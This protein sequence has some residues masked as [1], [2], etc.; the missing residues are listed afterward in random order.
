M[1]IK[2]FLFLTF[3]SFLTINES[4]S[5]EYSFSSKNK[6]AVKYYQTAEIAYKQR[7]L[8]I[9]D[10]ALQLSVKAD[11]EFIEAWLLLGDV[12]TELKK[13]ENAKIAYRRAIELNPDFFPPVY[14]FLGNLYF[15]DGQYL[16]ASKQ[17]E[18]FLQFEYLTDT[19]KKLAGI[20]LKKSIF[21]AFEMKNPKTSIPENL[22]NSIN[23]EADEYINF[24]NEDFDEL[25]L[26]RKSKIESDA[27]G[28]E[29]F[30]ESIYLSEKIGPAWNQ[31]NEIPL[32]WQQGLDVGGMNIA[33]DG[34]KM[35]FTGC[36]WPT[37]FGSCDIFVSFKKGQYWESPLNLG[38]QINSQWW[39]SQPIISSDGKKLYFTS[40]RAGGKGGSDIWMSVR[41]GSGKWS[42]AINLGDSINSP[43]DE[44][45]PVIHAD[46]KTLY[47]SSNGWQ[48]LG[49]YDLFI[50]KQDEAGR[51]E[52]AENLGYPINT[53]AEEI[54][55]FLSIDGQT[56]WISSNR[57]GGQGGF[58]I[59]SF[60]T[61]T[62]MQPEPV[63]YVKGIVSDLNTGKKLAAKVEISNLL[64]GIIDDSV[65]SDAVNGEFLLVLHPGTDYA[66][67]ISKKG[68][69][70][71]SENY[72]LNEISGDISVSSEFKLSPIQSGNSFVLNNI[73]FDFNSSVLQPSSFSELNKLF[74]LLQANMELN[75]LIEGHTDNIGSDE[76][77]KQL[78]TERAQSVY[79]YLVSKG[80]EASRMKYEG[81]GS[82]KPV[83][84]N[85][86]EEG[87]AKNRRTEIVIL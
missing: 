48:G 76:Y 36:N 53:N 43:G 79:H 83:D 64:T 17:Y 18:H 67:N 73:F 30:Q 14:Y 66:F 8:V 22:G 42:K 86:T 10:N 70:F 26:T 15:S 19:Q 58:D 65:S 52:K 31:A 13:N 6:K 60:P 74:V 47:F 75:I 40:K 78:S 32:E 51:W 68:Y 49:G 29:L 54:N 59:Y 16:N 81:F 27:S 12:S 69:L 61:Y 33:V 20:A 62:N 4:Y 63:F 9:A 37:S 41:L 5:Q 44:M 25:I 71:Y 82:T 34:R 46:G 80:I 28:N 11:P 57:K 35:Y 2:L 56:G 85:E 84:T 45:A 38:A 21:A 1:K 23:T 87:R 7:E 3:V 77:N 72:N 50:S 39:D 55:I 24:V